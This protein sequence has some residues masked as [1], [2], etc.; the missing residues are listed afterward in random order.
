MAVE[1]V[2]HVGSPFRAGSSKLAFPMRAAHP[3]PSTP[4]LGAHP[5]HHERGTRRIRGASA[6]GAGYFRATD[7]KANYGP[8]GGAE[9]YRLV[10]VDLPNGDTLRPLRRGTCPA[11][12]RASPP[13]T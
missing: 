3:P 7:G 13:P 2:H 8:L 5:Q 10:P 1:I 11:C 4:P 9:W 6:T 12:S